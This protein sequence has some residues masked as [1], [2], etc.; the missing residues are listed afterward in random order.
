MTMRS[1][2]SSI[3]SAFHMRVLE[4]IVIRK[5]DYGIFL[6]TNT[7]HRKL[8]VMMRR[9]DIYGHSKKCH[10]QWHIFI[11]KLTHVYLDV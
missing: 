4:E 9:N 2:T 5:W 10:C 7:V 8:V 1:W 3:F 11:L 6:T